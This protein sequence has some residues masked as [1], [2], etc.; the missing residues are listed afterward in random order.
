MSSVTGMDVRS[1]PILSSFAN[2]RVWLMLEGQKKKRENFACEKWGSDV[3]SD[4]LL[5]FCV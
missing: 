1:H 4:Y 5:S 2:F 3:R